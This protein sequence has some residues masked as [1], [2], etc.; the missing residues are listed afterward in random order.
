VVDWRSARW[1]LATQPID[2]VVTAPDRRRACFLRDQVRP[3]LI[4]RA[5]Q[6][7]PGCGPILFINVARYL[8]PQLAFLLKVGA[9]SL[10]SGLS[11]QPFA[12]FGFVLVVRAKGHDARIGPWRLT[13]LFKIEQSAI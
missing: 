8:A 1:A 10:I 6:G 2:P 11:G 12:L 13:N 7:D 9:A 3:E 4:G 5:D